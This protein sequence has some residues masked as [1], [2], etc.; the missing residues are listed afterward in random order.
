M[1]KV[2]V[3]TG[4]IYT[5]SKTRGIGSYANN[6][7]LSLDKLQ[8][9]DKSLKIDFIDF[10]KKDRK[11]FRKYDLLHFLHFNVVGK[12]NIKDI[13]IPFIVT[14]HDVIPL[15]YPNNFPLGIK[16][17]VR[18][19]IKT[20]KLQKA[21]A[22][23]TNSITSKKD[24]VRLL[25]IKSEKVFPFYMAASENCKKLDF[26]NNLVPTKKKFDLKEKFVL[27]IGDVNYNKNLFSL[28]KTC[29]VLKLNL[30]IVGKQSAN[31]EELSK[32][33]HIEL[34][35]VKALNSLINKSKY[36]KTLGFVEEEDLVKICN[37]ATVYC[38]PSLYEGFGIPVME[39]M[40]CGLPVV[41]SKTQALVEIYGKSS[42]VAD[43]T[44]LDD[45]K[46]AIEELFYSKKLLDFYSS[47]GV[48]FSKNYTWDLHAQKTITL[49]KEYA[50]K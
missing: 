37:L 23:I 7:I 3:D 17:R 46:K 22:I 2:A 12:D 41:I 15:I 24:I 32:S 21:S 11:F 39:A 26:R 27:Y 28:A 38:Q 20:K 1:F 50:K 31:L 8:N 33:D 16:G 5:D 35:H 30:V 19:F 42:L 18:L 49:Y 10:S 34:A 9:E 48:E 44:A 45:I 25:N 47:K 14:I 13:N 4:P 29:D 40:K 36:I 6:L 43:G